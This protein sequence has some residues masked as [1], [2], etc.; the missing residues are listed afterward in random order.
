MERKE[1]CERCPRQKG[2]EGLCE[3]GDRAP[4]SE[5]EFRVTEKNTKV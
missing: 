3:Q 4:S 1:N 2:G 5:K